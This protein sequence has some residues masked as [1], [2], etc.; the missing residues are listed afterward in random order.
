MDFGMVVILGFVLLVS[1]TSR[2]VSPE[3]RPSG[4]FSNC[5]MDGHLALTF[6]DGPSE[7]TDRF[8]D[9]LRQHR[10]KATFFIMGQKLNTTK[11]LNSLRRMKREGHTIASHTWSHPELLNLTTGEIE[12]EMWSTEQVIFNATGLVP[13]LMRPPYGSITDEIYAQLR[14]LGYQVVMW[15]LDTKDWS[16]SQYQPSLLYEG[17]GNHFSNT[18]SA[19]SS[20]IALH[21]DVY[22][23]TLGFLPNII[24]YIRTNGYRI[25]DM[26]TCLG[27]DTV[28]QTP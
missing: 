23:Q 8:L 19:E 2:A 16:V 7:Y 13:G 18:T 27:L 26:K 15:S 24:T 3:Y 17:Y 9:V 5:V 10:V 11:R 4:S 1:K 28:Y 14:K 20:W 12:E 22:G 25:V 6:D 21:H